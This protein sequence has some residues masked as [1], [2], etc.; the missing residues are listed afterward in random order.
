MAR[1]SGLVDVSRDD[2]PEWVTPFADPRGDSLADRLGGDRLGDGSDEAIARAFAHHENALCEAMDTYRVLTLR[3]LRALPWLL[4]WYIEHDRDPIALEPF[5]VFS[6]ALM[7]ASRRPSPATVPLGRQGRPSTLPRDL[8]IHHVVTTIRER[9]LART[10]KDACAKLVRALT[11]MRVR[12]EAPR[13]YWRRAVRAG[14]SRALTNL[15]Q[16]HWYINEG[17]GWPPRLADS[18]S[19]V[20]S[21]DALLVFDTFVGSCGEVGKM[22][23]ESAKTIWA[24]IRNGSFLRI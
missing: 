7:R 22:S 3:A 5:G 13:G 19:D 17:S 16:Y 12:P 8:A 14:H 23:D 18:R 4:E 21:L 2:E 11:W 9:G 6:A 20:P 10:D 15:H 24:W 1:W